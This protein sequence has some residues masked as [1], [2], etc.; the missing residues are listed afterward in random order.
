[1]ICQIYLFPKRQILDSFKLKE[2]AGDNCRFDENCRKLSKRVE[3]TEGIAE[4]GRYGQFLLFPQCIQKTST[5]D[6]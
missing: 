6:M 5:A 2:F 3:N 4:T 1:M